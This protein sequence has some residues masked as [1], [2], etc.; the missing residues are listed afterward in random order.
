MRTAVLT[1]VYPGFEKYFAAFAVSLRAQTDPDF[2]LLIFCDGVA[3]APDHFRSA[4]FRV[5]WC[6]GIGS[7]A[8]LRKQGIRWAVEQGYEA[9]IFADCDDFFSENRVAESKTGLKSS[10]LIF[11]EL[12]LFYNGSCKAIPL[13]G[14]RFSAEHRIVES[15]LFDMNCLGLSNTAVLARAVVSD[16]DRISSD[17][18]M[19]DWNIFVRLLKKGGAAIFHPNAVTY[20][21]QHDSNIAAPLLL[22]D[23]QIMKGVEV[24]AQHYRSLADLGRPYAGRAEDFEVLLSGIRSDCKFMHSYFESVRRFAPPLPLWWEAIKL[25]GELGL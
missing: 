2:D 6:Q 13:L 18:T 3:E 23:K 10:D 14:R 17:I 4:A 19:F 20:Y 24:K 5:I 22:S 1:F 7:I 8:A 15:T 9:I 12:V 21:R 11:N 25:P 16:L